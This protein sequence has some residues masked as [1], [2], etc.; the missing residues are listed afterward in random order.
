MQQ[1]SII[2]DVIFHHL[3]LYFYTRYAD[4]IG[5]KKNNR[6]AISSRMKTPSGMW[7][8]SWQQ[9]WVDVTSHLQLSMPIYRSMLTHQT[10]ED[11]MWLKIGLKQLEMIYPSWSSHTAANVSWYH[12]AK[13]PEI[14]TPSGW[15]LLFGLVP[16]ND[17]QIVQ[18]AYQ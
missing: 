8:L 1:F 14:P 3:A 2:T 15:P 11:Y 4:L 10:L 5:K 17:S 6:Q 9:Q 16:T 18:W 12:M 7:L 13:T